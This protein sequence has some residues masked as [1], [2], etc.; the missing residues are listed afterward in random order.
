[1]LFYGESEKRYVC[2]LLDTSTF[3]ESHSNGGPSNTTMVWMIMLGALSPRKG[4]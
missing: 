4:K 1:M 2:P 3:E